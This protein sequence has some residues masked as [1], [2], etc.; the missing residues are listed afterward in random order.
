MRVAEE[1]MSNKTI[2]IGSAVWTHSGNGVVVARYKEPLGH[3]YVYEVQLL[4][5]NKTIVTKTVYA[6]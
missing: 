6:N 5:T 3:Y 4:E 1:Y 2:K